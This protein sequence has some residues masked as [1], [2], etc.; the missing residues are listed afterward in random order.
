MLADPATAYRERLLPRIW[1]WLVLAG[2]A[3]MLAVAYGAAFGAA[4]GWLVWLIGLGIAVLLLWVTAPAVRVSRGELQVGAAAVPLDCIGT[5]EEVDAVRI[6]E[7]RGPGADARLFTAVRPW[8]CSAGVLVAIEDPT[9]PHPAWLIS[10]R[11]PDRLAQALTATMDP[12]P[13]DQRTSRTEE[14]A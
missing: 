1:V 12:R 8:S 10:S 7:L 5:V 13:R 14:D 4:T 9:D 2:L 6:R 11:H 3:G